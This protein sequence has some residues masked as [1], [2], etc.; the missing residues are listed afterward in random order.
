MSRPHPFFTDA[1]G[2]K[3]IYEEAREVLNFVSI[4]IYATFEENWLRALALERL[5]IICSKMEYTAYFCNKWDPD[6]VE[7]KRKQIH[8]VSFN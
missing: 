1:K 4:D 3:I 5:G 8:R 2:R 6:Y 7:H